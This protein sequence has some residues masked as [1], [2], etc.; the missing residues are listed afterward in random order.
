MVYTFYSVLQNSS[1]WWGNIESRIIILEIIVLDCCKMVDLAEYNSN[2]VF[3][4]GTVNLLYIYIYKKK[5]RI[6]IQVWEQY[7][8]KIKVDR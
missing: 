2:N 3:I 8:T 5:K 6:K 1:L 4:Y 7:V